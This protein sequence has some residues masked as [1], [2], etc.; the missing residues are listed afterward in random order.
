[1]KR[2]SGVRDEHRVTTFRA[3][4]SAAPLK[5]RYQGRGK[6]DESRLPRSIERGPIEAKLFGIPYEFR[7]H[8]FRAQL[9]AAPLKLRPLGILLYANAS[10]PRSIERGP[11]E[12]NDRRLK[13]LETA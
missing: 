6:S 1:M 8:A 9:S 11:I 7:G 2:V 4:L 5:R 10:L 3:Q 12:A 13:N